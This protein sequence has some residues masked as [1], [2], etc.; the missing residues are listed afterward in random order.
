MAAL[1]PGKLLRISLRSPRFSTPLNAAAKGLSR[2]GAHS[3]PTPG[4]QEQ[5]TTRA[6]HTATGEYSQGQSA[7]RLSEN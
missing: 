2:R 1:R 7:A 5:T 6:G 4:A 3:R